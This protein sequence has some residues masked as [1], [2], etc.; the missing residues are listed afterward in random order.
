MSCDCKVNLVKSL[1]KLLSDL[2]CKLQNIEVS[3]M[4]GIKLCVGN[5]KNCMIMFQINQ[6]WL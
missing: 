3:L 4:T 5:F 6:S 2:R 1:Y